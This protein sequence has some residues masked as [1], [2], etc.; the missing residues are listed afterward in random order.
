MHVRAGPT[1]H[2]GRPL[3]TSRVNRGSRPELDPGSAELRHDYDALVRRRGR[4]GKRLGQSV[5]CRLRSPI[6]QQW[7][8][9]AF[10][11]VSDI[12]GSE[13]AMAW[14]SDC[15]APLVRDFIAQ[16]H[17]LRDVRFPDAGPVNE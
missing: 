12:P 8:G 4:T 16:P 6:S 9:L 5:W 2:P 17:K 1:S 15:R 3:E 13:V 14:H 10:V 11:E 7:L